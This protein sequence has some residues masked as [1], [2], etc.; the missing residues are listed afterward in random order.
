MAS[1]EPFL[2]LA[3]EEDLENPMGMSVPTAASYTQPSASFPGSVPAATATPYNPA[4]R[5]GI[6][7]SIQSSSMSFETGGENFSQDIAGNHHTQCFNSCCD[8]RRAVLIVNGITIGFKLLAMIGV[9]FFVNYMNNNLEDIEA[10]MN[11][12]QVRKQVDEMFKSGQVAGFEWLFEIIEFVS[13]ALHACGV[14]GALKFK[15]WGIVVAGTMYALSLVTGIFSMDI[16][17]IIV[18]GLMLYPHVCMYNLM[19]EG[20]MTPHNY[21]KIASCCG[22]TQM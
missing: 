20:I 22:D 11:D 8:F 13:V 5:N 9:V 21:H 12:D 17:N 3:T 18:S 2:P 19:K 14:Y 4:Y 16:G 7:G 15:R 10:D 6:P 1:K